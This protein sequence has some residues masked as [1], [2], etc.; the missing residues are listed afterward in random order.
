MYAPNAQKTR[1][2]DTLI[3]ASI[4]AGNFNN[5]EQC[6]NDSSYPDGQ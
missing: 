1:I 3:L 2:V 6:V 5:A 4:S